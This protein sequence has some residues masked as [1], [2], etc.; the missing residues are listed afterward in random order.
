MPMK[1]R[2]NSLLRI[3]FAILIFGSTIAAHGESSKNHEVDYD[4]LGSQNRQ[5]I[6]YV[7]KDNYET[8]EKN[9]GQKAWLTIDWPS[10]APFLMKDDRY[11]LDSCLVPLQT[12]S[13]LCKSDMSSAKK[14]FAQA[15]SFSCEF[16]KPGSSGIQVYSRDLHFKMDPKNALPNDVQAQVLTAIG[17]S[18]PTTP[19]RNSQQQVKDQ[20][21]QAQKSAQEQKEKERLQKQ[22]EQERQVK[23]QVADAQ[24]KAAQ[25]AD[26]QKK[27]VQAMTAASD[28]YKAE[29][30]KIQDS[31]DT[32]EAK[33]KHYQDAAAAYQE[34]LKLITTGQGGGNP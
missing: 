2:R 21:Q 18:S 13:K 23:A 27:R 16:A 22:Q 32:P 17:I 28:A 33:A 25:V 14:F 4:L 9:C 30:K 15:D 6:V 24:A 26:A 5:A 29:V 11:S 34:Q 20:A 12:I 8:F 10:F 7:L 1:E 31:S 3:L 19:P